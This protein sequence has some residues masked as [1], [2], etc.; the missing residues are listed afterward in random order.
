M[1]SVVKE[2]RKLEKKHKGKKWSE[3][4]LASYAAIAAQ[5]T[6][7]VFFEEEERNGAIGTQNVVLTPERS[8]AI[9]R[10]LIGFGTPIWISTK[11]PPAPWPVKM[12]FAKFG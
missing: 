8:V 6:S 4:E 12:I 9:D 7:I 3:A 10:A 1:G 2:L 11:V 5:K